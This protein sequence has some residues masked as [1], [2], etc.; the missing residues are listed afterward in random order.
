MSY[1]N[2]DLILSNQIQLLLETLMSESIL[3]TDA[4]K[5]FLN[6]MTHNDLA[7]SYNHDMECQVNVAQ[8]G[9]E[10]I[11]G[12]F[13]GKRWHGWTD[14]V[15]MW[16]SFR[17]PYKANTEP[18]YKDVGI[19]FDLAEHAEAIGMTGWDWYNKLSRWVA[20]DFDAIVGHSEK[21]LTNEEL[22]Q[23][24][25]A[26]FDIKWVTIRKSTSGKGLHLYVYLEDAWTE[27]HNE[28]AALA[29]AILGKMSAL[30]GFDF[31]SKV[32]ICGG[33]MWIWHRKMKDTDGL[34]LIKQG[35]IL[36]DI[37]P[38]WKDHIK[39]ITGHRRKNLP[40]IIESNGKEDIFEELAG[41]RP[42][43]PLDEEHKKLINFLKDSDGLWWWDQ[44][45]HMLV[46]HTY[47]L[48][49]AH[50]DLHLKGIFKTNSPSTNINEQNC[51]CFPMRRGAW[52]IRR[53][54]PGVQEHDSWDQDGTGWTRCYL[55]REPDLATVAR[56][57]GGLEDPAGGFVF[58]EAEMA[59][60]AAE[61]LGVHVEVATPLG[62]R[63]TKLKEHKDGRLIIEVDHDSQDRADEMEGWLPKNKK[64]IRIYNTQIS[65]PTEQEVGN[66]D[67]L[68]RHLVTETNEDYGWMIKS[69]SRWRIEPLTHVRIALGSLGFNH[70]ETTT[71]LG[72]S[73]FNCWRTVNK[74]FQAEYPGDRQW[75]RNAAQYRFVPESNIEDLSYPTWL[76]ILNH[77]GSGLDDVIKK[78]GWAKA[79]G[80]VNGSDYLKCWVAS[81]FQEPTQPLP[82]LFLYGPQNSGKSIFHEALS[83]LLTRGYKFSD[84]ALISQAGFN[85]ELEGAIICI[86]EETDLRRN[87]QAY[88]RIKDWVTSRELLIHGKG[89]TPYHVPN[90]THWIQCSNDHQACPVF[91]GDTRITMCYVGLLDPIELIP[92]K[93][94]IVL[95]EKEASNF[96]AEILNLELPISN[97][98]L[99]IPALETED[100]TMVQQL[101]QTPLEAFILDKCKIVNG[102]LIKFSDFYDQYIKWM[103]PN[104]VHRWSKIRVGRELPPQFPKGR[105]RTNGQFYI[106]N[107]TWSNNEDENSPAGK[108][109]LKDGYLIT[110]DD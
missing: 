104:E 6:V 87:R 68:I 41:Q 1:Y 79:N 4:I 22:H 56:A 67:D 5:A 34:D 11:E 78:N 12:D 38:N 94:I 19:K 100:K 66:Y 33:N 20:F 105:S 28:H 58:R 7:D 51:F 39:V 83:L 17:I 30:T 95:L 46:T 21:S 25:Q 109:F 14:S 81:L 96:L 40:Q 18:E 65:A 61:N 99:N 71:I 102:R 75:N 63:K 53:Y 49:R 89:R 106:A 80:I 64:W 77:C 101:N 29:R 110:D 72:T 35:T 86:A 91:T 26:A 8:D 108:Y 13:K 43:I 62:S 15:T 50:E 10:R 69:D 70:K 88:N 31:S 59:V 44:D 23:V 84:A 42:R 37:P 85:A 93:K 90:T 36:K 3:R 74:P 52:S 47:Y 48:Q 60:K 24:Q 16:K 76:K 9:G 82:Y 27:N 55:N 103:D 54:T 97:D 98:R 57:Y 107:V 92:K 45:H 2:F 32:D 73:I